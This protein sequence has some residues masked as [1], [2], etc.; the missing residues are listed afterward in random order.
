MQWHRIALTHVGPLSVSTVYTP[1]CGYETAI[2]DAKDVV[3]PVQRY[4]SR[5]EA[6]DGHAEWVTLAP[7]LKRVLQL[8]WLGFIPDHETDLDLGE[9]Q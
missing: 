7:T 5:I 1:D 9:S 2:I 8:G 3:R 4:G 6:E